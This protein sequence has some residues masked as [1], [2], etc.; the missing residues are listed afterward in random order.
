MCGVRLSVSVSV[1]SQVSQCCFLMVVSNVTKWLEALATNCY[2]PNCFTQH[3]VQ[4]HSTVLVIVLCGVKL[5]DFHFLN[6]T[7]IMNTE[8]NLTS[9]STW[10]KQPH[11][12]N[13]AICW[14][15]SDDPGCMIADH[16]VSS[17]ATWCS[18][19]YFESFTAWR[20]MQ[21]LIDQTNKREIADW[22]LQK[23]LPIIS[24]QFYNFYYWR[25]SILWPI[26]HYYQNIIRT[27]LL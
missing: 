27:W 24:V 18:T 23:S 5:I 14:L 25:S 4:Y 10:R 15:V 2:S 17:D 9:N 12:L 22:L 11:L 3:T 8:W 20:M 16:N 7:E 6:N 13:F 1:V 21:L 26:S 19:K